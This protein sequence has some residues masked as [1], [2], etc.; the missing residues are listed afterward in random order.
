MS[1]VL[2]WLL[3]RAGPRPS[4]TARTVPPAAPASLDAAIGSSP[5]VWSPEAQAAIR[6]R[7]RLAAAG[8]WASR[9]LEAYERD[10]DV[11]LRNHFLAV[12]E[13][14]DTAMAIW[15]AIAAVTRRTGTDSLEQALASLGLSESEWLAQAGLNFQRAADAAKEDTRL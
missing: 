9:A 5:D 14:A 15:A 4:E 1:R 10:P 12:K 13:Q 2:A 11:F 7:L 6:S 8:E 3:R